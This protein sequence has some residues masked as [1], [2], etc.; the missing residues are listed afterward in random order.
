M[1]KSESNIVVILGMPRAASTSIFF[2]LSKNENFDNSLIKEKNLFYYHKLKELNKLR[3]KNVQK[4]K[5]Y[6]DGNSSYFLSKDL[7]NNIAK[8]DERIFS[9]LILR[10]PKSW[11][12]SMA[13]QLKRLKK[14]NHYEEIFNGIKYDSEIFLRYYDGFIQERISLIKNKFKNLL[15]LDY[16]KIDDLNYLN[17]SFSDFFG[18]KWDIEKTVKLN[19]RKSAL[20]QSSMFLNTVSSINN[21][22]ESIKIVKNFLFNLQTLI[23]RRK[24]DYTMEEKKKL[25]NI[26]K[27]LD[28]DKLMKKDIEYYNETIKY[29]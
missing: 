25:N 6:I 22:F 28:L 8:F 15:I 12:N 19:D 7:I 4:N 2:T 29:L 24:V 21:F 23:F 17:T 1:S 18:F 10:D 11:I 16:S 26:F 3:Y 9:I 27:K 20:F 13:Y 5:F 14:I